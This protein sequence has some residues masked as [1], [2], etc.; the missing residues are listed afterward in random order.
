M[1]IEGQDRSSERGI[2]LIIVMIVIVVLAIL[3]GGFAYSMKVETRLAR[4]SSFDAELD[5]LGRSGV[6][7]AR[8]VLGEQVRNPDPE[9][10]MYSGLDQRWAGGPRNTNEPLVHVEQT[11]EMAQGE[12]FTWRIKDMESKFNL[13][14]IRDERF[15]PVL[16]RALEMLG[17]DPIQTTDIVESYLDWVD[18]DDN[19]RMQGAESEFYINL[20]P[21]APYV[22]KNGL[23]DDVSELLLL[24]G[25]TPEIYF[26][27]PRAASMP[28]L[29]AAPR[30]TT[31]GGG[32]PAA[33]TGA[34]SSVGLMDLFTTISAAGMGVNVNTASPEVL[35]L[36]PGMDEALARSIVDTRAGPDHQ[37]GTDDDIPFLRQSEL[38]NVPGMI[39]EVMQAMQSYLVVNSGIFVITVEARVGEHVRWYEALVQRRNAVEIPILYLRPL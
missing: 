10:R 34:S 16:Q 26:G 7:Y 33:G 22:A 19:K 27:A 3:A 20:N 38:I 28:R 5:N 21:A 35:Q 11:I 29:G 24:R 39:P 4:S 30:A 12:T 15:S 6:E 14:V 23:M 32:Q 31:L 36:L 9:Q 13:S 37:D 2:A 8:W 25:M 18:P 1:I 17:A